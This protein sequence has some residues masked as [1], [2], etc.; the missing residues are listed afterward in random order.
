MAIPE[1][2]RKPKTEEVKKKIRETLRETRE[3]VKKAKEKQ[4]R[5]PLH[6]STTTNTVEKLRLEVERVPS[7]VPDN[8]ERLTQEVTEQIRQTVIQ[9]SKRLNIK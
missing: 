7:Q 4:D 9:A 5:V 8:I 2:V 1:Y 3:R 6:Q